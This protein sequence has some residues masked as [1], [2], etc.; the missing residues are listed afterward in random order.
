[1]QHMDITLAIYY[2]RKEQLPTEHDEGNENNYSK[3]I[4]L[5]KKQK[6]LAQKLERLA[7]N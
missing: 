3:E 4:L 1:M 6:D 2:S 7:T 5:A